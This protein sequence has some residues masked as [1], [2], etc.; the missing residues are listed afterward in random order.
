MAS[1]LTRRL[2]EERL[3]DFFQFGALAFRA[4]HLLRLV[5]LDGQ[6]FTKFVMAL[7]ADVFVKGH[8]VVRFVVEGLASFDEKIFLKLS[9]TSRFLPKVHRYLP[10]AIVGIAHTQSPRCEIGREP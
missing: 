7:A 2:R 5:F 8:I 10:S 6:H 4:V 3:D 9:H 1:R